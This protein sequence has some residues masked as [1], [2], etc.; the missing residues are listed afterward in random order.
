[1]K[2]AVLAVVCVHVAVFVVLLIQGC[3]QEPA[4]LKEEASNTNL[5][6][7]AQSTNQPVIEASNAPVAPSN[8]PPGLPLADT[9]APLPPVSADYTIVRGDT[10]NRLARTFHTT[11]KSILEANPGVKATRLQIGQKIHLPALAGP[12]ATNEVRTSS[13]DPG[14]T[15]S[16]EVIT[17]LGRAITCKGLRVNLAPRSRPFAKLM[18]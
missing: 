12:V 2:V 1:V 10:F 18:V 11:T 8:A 17:R 7:A 4:T 14:A 3:R 9:A 6:E 5:S 13:G 15:A 16:G